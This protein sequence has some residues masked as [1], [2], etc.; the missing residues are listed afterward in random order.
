MVSTSNSRWFL[1]SQYFLYFGV[2]GVFLPFFSLYCYR[3]GFSGWQIGTL[4]AARSI[5]LIV[6]SLLWSLLADRFRRRGPIYVICNFISAAL[7]GLFLLTTDYVW[8]LAATIAYGIFYAPLI[9]F[10][11]AFAME[12]LGQDKKRYGR[13]RAWGSLAFI[14]TVLTLGRAIELYSIRIIVGLI[15]AVSWIQAFLS[16]GYPRLAI[17]PQL[18]FSDG[19]RQ[20]FTPRVAVFLV[21]ALLMLFSH[22]AYYA[23]F[24]IHLDGL[25][26]SG[27][28]IGAC[29]AA[30][31]GAE[32]IT[33]FFSN[34][35]FKRFAYTTVLCLSFGAAV[36]RWTGLWLV[37]SAGGI[38]IL[39]LT[40][41][42]TYAAFHMASIL[43]MDSLAPP[44]AKTV[45]Q[46]ANN[47]VSYG[48]GLMLGFLASGLLYEK[49]G[50]AALFALSAAAALLAGLIFI[51][52]NTYNQKTA[53]HHS[54]F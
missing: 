2:M 38:I 6:F 40:H 33:M 32:I 45:A 34:R 46:A 14:A 20:M 5:V 31:V 4:S 47:A 53:Q 12:S 37:E 13:M 43:Y 18:R 10:L 16:P 15:F 51:G 8:M 48:L 49:L 42:A 17:E 3:L 35:L 1:A 7:W 54:E 41:A 23:F 52:F 19:L 28:F 21:C 9:A 24:S 27:F 30:A 39:Q 22:G 36:M 50:S 44:G 29:W 26:Y 25:G 11:E